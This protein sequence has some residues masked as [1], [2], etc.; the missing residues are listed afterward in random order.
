[1][2][3]PAQQ[4]ERE[5]SNSAGRDPRPRAQQRR[6]EVRRSEVPS[7]P[8]ARCQLV[9]RGSAC[10]RPRSAKEF[11]EPPTVSRCFPIGYTC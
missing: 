4:Y 2:P 7:D 11:R 9:S 5:Q 3:T 8:R 10:R 1:V 6:S